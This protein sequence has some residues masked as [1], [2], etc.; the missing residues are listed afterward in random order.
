[1]QWEFWVEDA[2]RRTDER[3]SMADLCISRG[4]KMHDAFSAPN[5]FLLLAT[6]TKY[7]RIRFLGIIFSSFQKHER[8]T[9]SFDLHCSKNTA[10][11]ALNNLRTFL[12][13][14]TTQIILQKI[15]TIKNN[16]GERYYLLEKC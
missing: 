7:A 10:L 12:V 3:G 1:M 14:K 13:C 2:S 6:T 16:E 9:I 11:D 15:S 4:S 8:S 5:D